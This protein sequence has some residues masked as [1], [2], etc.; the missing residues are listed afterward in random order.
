MSISPDPRTFRPSTSTVSIALMSLAGVC[1]K[2]GR[3]ACGSVVEFIHVIRQSS[4]KLIDTG[5][6]GLE[7]VPVLNAGPFPLFPLSFPVQSD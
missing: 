5:Y 3:L 4:A 1:R 7:M 2:P 6:K